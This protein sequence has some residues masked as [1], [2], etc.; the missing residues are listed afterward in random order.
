MIEFRVRGN[1]VYSRCRARERAEQIERYHADIEIGRARGAANQAKRRAD[2]A[3]APCIQRSSK[4]HRET[5]GK[6]KNRKRLDRMKAERP[7]E[8]KSW[9]YQ[10]QCRVKITGT[11]LERIWAA[12]NGKCGLT[13]RAMT[14]QTAELDHIVPISR[15]GSLEI[16]NLRWLCSEANQAKGK[17]LDHEFFAICEEVSEYIGRA[18]LA[19]I[20]H[21]E[22]A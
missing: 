4:K 9:K 6:G 8:W 22:A 7:F 20:N 10:T 17:M 11:E 21:R 13:G 15:G 16:G 3:K 19:H 2:P 5:W 14:P 18:A 1:K 12:Q